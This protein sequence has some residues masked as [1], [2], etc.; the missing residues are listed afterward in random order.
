MIIT[1]RK[2]VNV[3]YTLRMAVFALLCFLTSI[4][5]LAQDERTLRIGITQYPANLHP[6]IESML[7][8]SYVLGFTQ[9]QLTAYNANWDLVCLAC[10]EL[11]TIENGLAVLERTPEDKEGIA[12]T[13]EIHPNARWGDGVPL[14]TRDLE[15]A[16]ELGKNPL[17]GLPPRRCIG[18]YTR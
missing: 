17:S 14:T 8:K 16:V 6:N 11:P 1:D 12:V 10:T 7:A 18:R 4:H 9:R 5:A 3:M 13:F 2:S 15:F